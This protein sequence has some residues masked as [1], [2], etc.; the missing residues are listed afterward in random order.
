MGKARKRG[1]EHATIPY[2]CHASFQCTQT[3]LHKPI[4][5]RN[6]HRLRHLF[7]GPTA[8]RHN[9]PHVHIGSKRGHRHKARIAGYV[10][11][12]VGQRIRLQRGQHL[13]RAV[14]HVHVGSLG[15][16]DEVGLV[17]CGV[18][19]TGE[20]DDWVVAVEVGNVFGRFGSVAGRVFGVFSVYENLGALS[21]A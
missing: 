3:Y 8:L 4:M 20:F 17:G 16:G 13:A 15:A 9:L 10:H 11:R 14:E 7:E 1:P 21:E 19:S 2:Q 5:P 6:V 18:H 12:V